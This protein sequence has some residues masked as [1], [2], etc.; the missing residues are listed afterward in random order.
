MEIETNL[1]LLSQGNSSTH[2]EG[3][4]SAEEDEAGELA[5]GGAGGASALA[6]WRVCSRRRLSLSR[7]IR[8]LS[9]L[10]RPPSPK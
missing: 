5:A 10:S 9:L 2:Y 8:A 1:G 7:N 4:R 3:C 6:L